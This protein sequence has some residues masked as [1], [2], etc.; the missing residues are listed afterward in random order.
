MSKSTCSLFL[1]GVV[2]KRWTTHFGGSQRRSLGMAG[3]QKRYSTDFVAL[4]FPHFAAFVPRLS[5]PY[6]DA[7]CKPNLR[8]CNCE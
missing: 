4:A 3:F 8:R 5:H 7:P 1:G 6:I 2:T